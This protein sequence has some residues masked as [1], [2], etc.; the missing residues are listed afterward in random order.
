MTYESCDLCP[1]MCGVD[2]TAQSLG[3]CG[4]TSTVRAAR[5]ALHMWEEP[6]IS[7]VNG[8]GTIFFSG[9]T[10]RCCFCQNYQI[11]SEHFGKEL[12]VRQLAD[13]FLRL[14]DKGA[15]NINL[16]TATQYLPSVIQALDLVRH[17]LF[18]PVVFNCGGYE[19]LETIRAMDGYVDVY[20][21]DFKYLSSALSQAYSKAADYF[22]VAGRAITAMVNQTGAPVFEDYSVEKGSCRLIK[23]GVLIRHL[24]LPGH[25]DDS[26]KILSWIKENLPEKKYC[27]SLMSQYTPFYHSKDFPELNRRITTYEYNKVLDYA[28][29]LG[30][31]DGYMQKKSS[32]KE[33]Y[34]PPFDLE[35]LDF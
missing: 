20:L 27:I 31:T 33:E 26:I 14:Q 1:R 17:Q 24:V 21:P 3:F 13:I 10:L 9:C 28:I 5:S 30:L 34:T 22:D 6:C 4:C 18:I 2:R 25:R 29:K 12:T 19:R 15:H 35:G 16:V 8:S 23:R 11:S 32:A 7:G